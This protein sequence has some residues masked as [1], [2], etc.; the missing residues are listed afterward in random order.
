M[1]ISMNIPLP[2][3]RTIRP[4]LAAE[5]PVPMPVREIYH[6]G[7]WAVTAGF[8]GQIDDRTHRSKNNHPHR[9]GCPQ[10]TTTS[11][12]LGLKKPMSVHS[13]HPT[14]G[15]TRPCIDGPSGKHISPYGGEI[16]SACHTHPGRKVRLHCPSP[17]SPMA[18]SVQ[19]YS[20][21]ICSTTSNDLSS[22]GNTSQV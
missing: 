17:R 2:Q 22:S 8:P 7:E 13:R 9:P 16:G 10:V 15:R 1:S 11:G 18:S 5:C 20:L 19:R 12:S 21:V 6:P 3:P 4:A 14:K